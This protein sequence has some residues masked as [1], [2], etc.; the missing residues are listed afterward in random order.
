M[1]T[2]YGIPSL[3]L[4]VHEHRVLDYCVQYRETDLE[5]VERIL[6][7]A[8]LFYFFDEPI[9]EGQ[10]E[11]VV[12]ADN[13]SAYRPLGL[14]DPIEEDP[15][16]EEK[17]GLF[18]KLSDAILDD[19]TLRFDRGKAGI[20][21]GDRFR[22]FSYGR[23]LRTQAVDVNVFDFERPLAKLEAADDFERHATHAQDL[24]AEVATAAVLD[25]AAPERE[26]VGLE[27]GALRSYEHSVGGDSPELL[28]GRAQRRL[29]RQRS[30]A[31]F[32]QGVGNCRRLQP[33]RTFRLKG[34]RQEDLNQ[35]Y[36]V[37]SVEH[38]AFTP[39]HGAPKGKDKN[40]PYQTHMTCIPAGV[41]YRPKRQLRPWRH[42]LETATIVGPPGETIHVDD[43]GRVKVQFHWDREG[44]G[45]GTNSC[46]VRVAQPWAGPG[47][48]LQFALR[49]G[50]EVLVGFLS[51][52]RDFPVV[53]GC[54][55]N[56]I[57]PAP[58]GGSQATSVGIRTRSVGG[59]DSDTGGNELKFEDT[60]GGERVTLRAERQLAMHIG[61]DYDTDAGGN[62]QLLV[63]G[64]YRT[65]VGRDHSLAVMGAQ[66]LKVTGAQTNSVA[67]RVD[68]VGGD[69]RRTVDGRLGLEIGGYNLRNNA[70]HHIEVRGA[71]SLTVGT[72]Q[73]PR[74][75]HTS[76]YGQYGADATETMTLSANERMVLRSG[77][78]S[79]VIRPEGVLIT[80]PKIAVAATESLLLKGP[81]PLLELADEAH[82]LADTIRLFGKGGSLELDAEAAH[83]N[84]KLVKI[85]CGAGSVSKQEQEEETEVQQFDWCCLDMH[86]EPLAGKNYLLTGIGVRI[87]GTTDQDGHIKQ[88]LPAELKEVKLMIW[89]EQFPEGPRWSWNIQLGDL[90][91]VNTPHGAQ[92]RLASLGYFHE[93]PGDDETQAFVAALMA[94]QH[95]FDLPPSGALDDATTAK[96]DELY[97]V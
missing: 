65:E 38:D 12:L 61:A 9:S 67:S 80:S 44:D 3:Q 48:G 55:H 29:E 90:P 81:G 54:L 26:I 53:L 51:D 21:S 39:E 75:H 94:F 89:P 52:R 40:R 72:E 47:F 93:Q 85:N 37:V 24:G 10:S 96:L 50:M 31:M 15:K 36:V 17:K 33:G 22:E 27:A 68:V 92:I 45:T 56:A 8:G 95:D 19:S 83:L 73:E 69:E 88:E 60:A 57:N 2:E 70:D 4:L 91:P 76:V 63:R 77:D 5:F 71:S 11:R 82:L 86:N 30:N 41:T 49:V 84:G 59:D 35:D 7:D 18:G 79:L 1:L 28:D 64:G 43:Y 74:T 66:D 34:H 32:G 46:W 13:V 16:Q 97:P 23:E 14:R 87:T 78:S 20:G 6:A 25:G 58:Y 42:I 62:A